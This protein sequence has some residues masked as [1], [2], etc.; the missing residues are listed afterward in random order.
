MSADIHIVQAEGSDPYA[1]DAIFADQHVEDSALEIH[2][3]AMKLPPEERY[4]FLSDWV[5][6]GR[7]HNS[8]R[9]QIGFTQTNPSPVSVDFP[10]EG[11]SKQPRVRQQTGGELVSPAWDLITAAQA[12]QQLQGLRKQVAEWQPVPQQ[13][14]EIS[15]TAMLALIDIAGKDDRSAVGSIEQLVKAAAS[16]PSDAGPTPAELL[17]LCR[18][19][20]FAPIREGIVACSE[21]YRSWMNSVVYRTAT[22][23]HFKAMLSQ[24]R[25]FQS[26]WLD[27]PTLPLSAQPIEQWTRISRS[28]AKT[29]GMGSPISKWDYQPGYVENVASHDDDYL[30]FN[31]P[32]RG[33][34]QVEC[35]VSGFGWRD[36]QL[37]VAGTW[38]A[39]VYTLKDI[40]IGTFR[41][42]LP[43]IHFEPP[44]TRVKQWIHYRTVVRDQVA[45]TYFNGRRVHDEVL[46]ADHDPWVAVRSSARHDGAVR[47]LRISGQPTIPAELN[48]SS[49]GS[50]ESWLEYYDEALAGRSGW[51]HIDSDSEGGVIGHSRDLP[52]SSSLTESG[53]ELSGSSDQQ[54]NQTEI[55]SRFGVRESLFRYN[56][57]IVEDGAID[58]DFVY[59]PGQAIVHPALDRL[60]FLLHPEGVHIHWITD[61]K[62]DRTD[63]L[64]SNSTV[65]AEHRRG[66]DTLPLQSGEWNHLKLAVAG[67]TVSLTLNDVLIYERPLEPANQR[68]FGLFHFADQTHAR[69]RNIVWQGNWPRELPPLADQELAIDTVGF[70]DRGLEKLSAVFEHDFVS[71]GL[72]MELFTII[73]GDP[74]AHIRRVDEGVLTTRPG[75]GG[76]RNAT[77]A[78]ALSVHGDFDIIASYKEFETNPVEGGNGTAQLI[79]M[80][81]NP[82]SD[83]L[84]VS[85]KHIHNTNGTH[86]DISQCFTVKRPV[87]GERRDYFGGEPM[88]ETSGR[89]RLSRRGNTAYFLTAEGDSPHFQLRGQREVATDDIQNQGLRLMALIFREGG[90]VGVVWDHLLVRAESLSGRAVEDFD[91]QLVQLNEERDQLKSEFSFDFTKQGP[92]ETLF[93]RWTDRRPWNKEDGGLLIVAPGTEAWTSAG[94]SLLNSV[95]GDFD[96]SIEFD[97]LKFDRPMAGKR[98]AVYLQLELADEARTQLSAIFT[99]NDAGITEAIAQVREPRGQ[100]KYD[101][102]T[103]GSLSF[104]DATALR[105]ARRNERLTFL[106][107]SKASK[108]ERIIGYLDRPA[109]PIPESSIR[110]L[111]H[112]GDPDLETRVLWKSINVRADSVSKPNEVTAQA[113]DSGILDSVINLFRKPAE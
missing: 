64:S 34:F 98:C 21:R 25:S 67:D 55:I 53:F 5:L 93:Y 95:A 94:S 2:R 86:Q 99:N 42:D 23:R 6:P 43:R 90:A 59:V 20:N 113:D 105:I 27:E 101:Y 79:A 88:E 7:T 52:A 92:P 91:S 57:P 17:V 41:R 12:T 110:L 66:P 16:N 50:A 78:P 62:F 39:P 84:I 1:L 32:L 72:P 11:L 71:D 22:K 54:T 4:E 44:I 61:G 85:R 40:D 106:V 51:Q 111:V 9:I 47:N 18:G 73:R 10:S 109:A 107:A 97:V 29:R 83:E 24:L 13:S 69:V 108:T 75:T 60:A 96:I 80:L 70:L 100:G 81:N 58:Y 38:V 65:E 56:R 26:A 46:L 63:V 87:D 28:R 3:Q 82:T 68:T 33:N 15:R 76:Y 102:R 74:K 37:S 89:L 104:A 31:S 30:Y 45:T 112:T 8:L 48:I 77:I 103:V 35:D 19:V 36:T 14:D 49:A